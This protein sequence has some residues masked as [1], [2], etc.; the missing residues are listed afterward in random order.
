MV[1]ELCNDVGDPAQ[2]REARNAGS[3]VVEGV[4]V[5]GQRLWPEDQDRLARGF[6]TAHCTLQCVRDGVVKSDDS[7]IGYSGLVDG[8]KG[9][10]RGIAQP[11]SVLPTAVACSFSYHR[12]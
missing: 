2:R 11:R 5:E 9:K 4:L 1:W 12:I 8:M 3:E 6:L 7:V 10:Y